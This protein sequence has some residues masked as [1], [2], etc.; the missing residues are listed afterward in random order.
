MGSYKNR[1]QLV[2]AALLICVSYAG[3]EHSALTMTLLT[4]GI[5]LTGVQYGGG[6]YLSPGD[7]APRY[8]GV[9]Y[10]ISNTVAT[11]PGFLSPMAIG[12]L[13]VD[14]TQ[15]QWR[16]VFFIAAAVYVFGSTFFNIF[17]S[18]SLQPWASA[19]IE[20]C[21]EKDPSVDGDVE[22]ANFPQEKHSE[23]KPYTDINCTRM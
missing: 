11:L 6:L 13:T 23:D 2:P 1:C 19:P 22:L 14:Q 5:A 21:I 18:A 8:A 17:A 20:M 16:Y 15:E 4:I 9:V 7:I 10:G 3:R 12:Y